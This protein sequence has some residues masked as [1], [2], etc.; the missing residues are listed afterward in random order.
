MA[1]SLARNSDIHFDHSFEMYS[2]L[3]LKEYDDMVIIKIPMK[4]Q[5]KKSKV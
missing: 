1:A 5:G 3:P 2:F 4:I